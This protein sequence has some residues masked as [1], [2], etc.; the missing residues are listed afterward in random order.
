MST[1]DELVVS[2]CSFTADYIKWRN[3]RLKRKHKKNT[4]QYFNE[5][6]EKYE[7]YTYEYIEPFSTLD[8]YIGKHFNLKPINLG[9]PGGSNRDIFERSVDYIAENSQKVKILIVNWTW[10]G[11]MSFMKQYKPI[12]YETLQYDYTSSEEQIENNFMKNT[13]SFVLL[14]FMYKNNYLNIEFDIDL[15]FR[16]SFL[17]EKLCENLNIKFVQSFTFGANIKEPLLI[18]HSLLYNINLDNFYGYPGDLNLGGFALFDK[19]N[20]KYWVS[21]YDSHP[22][23]LAHKKAAED[24]INFIEKRRL[25]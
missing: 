16:Y 2:G 1:K 22:N 24:L 23:E 21:K 3:D 4:V 12:Q 10:F 25:L 19:D 8:Y 7:F 14:D 6:T 17:L 9:I 11:R 13:E 18:D 5:E 15:L 20:K